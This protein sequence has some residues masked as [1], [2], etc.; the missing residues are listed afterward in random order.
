M[1]IIGVKTDPMR[2]KKSVISSIG[3]KIAA[4]VPTMVTITAMPLLDALL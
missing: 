1:A 3:Y 4:I 2:Y